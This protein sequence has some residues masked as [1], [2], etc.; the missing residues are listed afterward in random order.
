MKD[1]ELEKADADTLIEDIYRFKRE[2]AED[3][4]MMEILIEY[5]FQH[6][7]PLQELGN[8]ISEHKIFVNILEKE[9]TREKYIRV[10]EEEETFDEEEW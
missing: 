10:E 5:S 4:T 2:K 7:I 1:K 6:E 3:L 9:L 8:I